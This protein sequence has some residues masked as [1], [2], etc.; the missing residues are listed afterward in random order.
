MTCLGS[1]GDRWLGRDST[2]RTTGHPPFTQGSATS[3]GARAAVLLMWQALG[4]GLQGSVPKGP[5]QRVGNSL[6]MW[7]RA[8]NLQCHPARLTLPGC[9]T[10][11]QWVNLS[12][13]LFTL[14]VKWGLNA[15]RSVKCSALGLL[16][17]PELRIG[18][19]QMPLVVFMAII[20]T[21]GWSPTWRWVLH[22]PP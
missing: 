1:H 19:S 21:L 3:S 8:W 12:G 17:C 14:L 5:R 18:A 7:W 15:I 11:G 2:P 6:A 16:I 22:P 10:F 20:I 4:K 13:P 9:V